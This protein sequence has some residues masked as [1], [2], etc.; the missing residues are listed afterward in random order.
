MGHLVPVKLRGIRL[1][2]ILLGRN[3]PQGQS[4]RFSTALMNVP[5]SNSENHQHRSDNIERMGSSHS[6]NENC[7][8]TDK[9][10]S[11]D[12]I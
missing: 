12:E 5:R 2:L 7:V 8:D 4:C 10:G 6:L 3:E 1:H 9:S 11:F